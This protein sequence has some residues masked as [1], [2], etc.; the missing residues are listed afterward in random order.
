[1]L[2]SRHHRA[3]ARRRPAGDR[4]L[5]APGSGGPFPV[6]LERTPYDKSAPSRSEITAADAAAAL[7]RTRSRPIS[8]AHGYAVAYQDCRGR[9]R[10]G[11]RL[12]EVSE[13]GRRTATTRSPG[14]C[15]SLGATAASQLW[16]CL[17]PRTRRWRSAASIRPGLAAQF[18]DCGGFSNAYRSGIRHGGAFDLKQATWAY[19][20]ALADAK[21]PAVKAALKPED[22]A[23][24]IARMPWQLRRGDSPLSA[25]PEYEDYLFEQWSHG[26]LRRILEAARHLCRGLLR[27]LCRCADGASV[28]LVRPLRPHR[29]RE[30]SRPVARRAR[31]AAADPRAV[32]AWRSVAELCRRC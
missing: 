19:R 20:N 13:R 8:S 9:Y 28:G 30:L 4:R 24:W 2:R 15:A 18:L 5:S 21:D 25:A 31:A 1:M 6:M 10:S 17:T 16:A 23:A 32:D 29:G 12:H 11:G 3:G 14:W 26:L 7:A 27:P 22:I